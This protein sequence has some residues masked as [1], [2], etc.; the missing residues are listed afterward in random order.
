LQV[1]GTTYLLCV[2]RAQGGKKR[3]SR[4]RF[5]QKTLPQTT[6]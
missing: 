4:F 3:R 1:W 2:E 5:T 6:R